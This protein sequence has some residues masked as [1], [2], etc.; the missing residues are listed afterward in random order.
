MAGSSVAVAQRFCGIAQSP[1][2]LP[3][4]GR[5]LVIFCL[6]STTSARK[7]MR[8]ISPLLSQLVSIRMPGSSFGVIVRPWNLPSD[9]NP[10]RWPQESAARI[11][12]KTMPLHDSPDR[13]PCPLCNGHPDQHAGYALPAGLERHLIGKLGQRQCVVMKAA[14]TLLTEEWHRKRQD[15]ST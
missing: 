15:K 4:F 9:F 5:I 2:Y 1:G 14:Q 13:A 11:I 8:S 6:P 3:I 7:L 10:Y 12:A